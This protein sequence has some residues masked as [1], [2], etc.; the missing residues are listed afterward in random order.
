MVETG[1]GHLGHPGHVLSGSSGFDPVYKMS[2]SD[3]DPALDHVCY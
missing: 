1:A 2:G 3:L